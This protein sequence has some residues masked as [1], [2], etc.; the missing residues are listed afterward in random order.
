VKLDGVFLYFTDS[1]GNDARLREGDADSGS[2]KVG[3]IEE[4]RKGG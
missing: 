4:V 3:K 1:G 2:E